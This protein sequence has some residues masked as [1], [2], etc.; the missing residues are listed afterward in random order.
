MKR[1]VVTGMGAVS[2]NGIGREEFWKA[3]ASGVSGTDRVTLY[4]DTDVGRSE[5]YE[6]Y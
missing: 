6:L 1:V 4:D 2:P 3:T 5:G